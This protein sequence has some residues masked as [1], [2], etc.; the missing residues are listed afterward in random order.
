NNRGS[1]IT[2]PSTPMKPLTNADI[3]ALQNQ[4]VKSTPRLKILRLFTATTSSAGGGAGMVSASISSSTLPSPSVSTMTSTSINS[5]TVTTNQ[6]TTSAT[7][8]E[9]QPTGI[10]P[11]ITS[12]ISTVEITPA[13][14]QSPQFASTTSISPS[15]PTP[16]ASRPPSSPMMQV[17]SPSSPGSSLHAP[18][19]NHFR[20]FSITR[21][22]KNSLMMGGSTNTNSGSPTSSSSS[23]SS[24]ISSS[25][26]T[27]PG[28]KSSP[29]SKSSNNISITNTKTLISTRN[30][31]ESSSVYGSNQSG[32]DSSTSTS[33]SDDKRH[34]NVSSSSNVS[35][36]SSS[37]SNASSRSTTPTNE[38]ASKK[39]VDSEYS[40]SEMEMQELDEQDDDEQQ[41]EQPER[42]SSRVS[43]HEDDEV[44]FQTIVVPNSTI[45]TTTTKTNTNTTITKST[46]IV[47]GQLGARSSRVSIGSKRS[48]HGHHGQHGHGRVNAVS[49]RNGSGRVGGPSRM[50][51]SH[52]MMRNNSFSS[53]YSTK[54]F[55]SVVDKYMYDDQDE[56]EQQ[57]GET[58]QLGNSNDLT[59]EQ[60]DEDQ[61]DHEME[62]ED[63]T[64]TETET[65]A[66][67]I[68]TT[69]TVD[70]NTNTSKKQQKSANNGIKK[71]RFDWA[72][73]RFA[74]L[75]KNMKN[76]PG[77]PSTDTG[78]D[79][80][81]R[82]TIPLGES[83]H[84]HHHQRPFRTDSEVSTTSSNGSYIS[85]HRIIPIA[86]EPLKTEEYSGDGNRNMGRRGSD[87]HDTLLNT[88][89]DIVA[90][91][92]DLIDDSQVEM[93]VVES[94]STTS[95][96]NKV[97]RTLSLKRKVTIGNGN[98]GRKDSW[99]SNG[100]GEGIVVEED[101]GAGDCLGYYAESI[102][103]SE[104][105]GNDCDDIGE[106]EFGGE[107]DVQD[108]TLIEEYLVEH[109]VSEDGEEID[110]EEMGLDMEMEIEDVDDPS[111]FFQLA[112]ARHSQLLKTNND[113][114]DDQNED[115]ETNEIAYSRRPSH[116]VSGSDGSM[117][118]TFSSVPILMSSK[119]SI[120]S[121]EP[122][123]PI[124]SAPINDYPNTM[125]PYFSSAD[126]CSLLP[127]DGFIVVD[128][129]TV[130][131]ISSRRGSEGGLSTLTSL[132][133]QPITIIPEARSRIPSGDVD[134]VDG[135]GGIGQDKEQDGDDT[136]NTGGVVT[137]DRNQSYGNVDNNNKIYGSSGRI[138][139][140]VER[141]KRHFSDATTLPASI[142]D[143]VYLDDSSDRD[144]NDLDNEIIDGGINVNE[145]D[146]FEV[147][148]I[149]IDTEHGDTDAVSADLGTEMDIHVDSNIMFHCDAVS[150]KDL[151]SASDGTVTGATAPATNTTT[152][153][154]PT[155]STVPSLRSSVA[156]AQSI[157]SAV[158]SD[159]ITTTNTN[160][161]EITRTSTSTS[162][163]AVSASPSPTPRRVVSKV[164][165]VVTLDRKRGTSTVTVSVS[166]L[167]D[168]NSSNSGNCNASGISDKSGAAKVIES[169]NEKGAEESG[170]KEVDANAM[171]V[172]LEEG[173]GVGG[174]G[175][176]KGNDKGGKSDSG[177]GKKKV[178]FISAGKKNSRDLEGKK[179]RSSGFAKFLQLLSS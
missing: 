71:S 22:S 23:S 12:S 124:V 47:K 133:S 162:T 24:S 146:E 4:S 170:D 102:L 27:K 91:L 61:E 15:T 117:I 129:K 73:E 85:V 142:S 108:D 109:W 130:I 175:E 115:D 92:A 84:H 42:S 33:T 56:D 148:E 86:G 8:A 123:T 97:G 159:V 30:K 62:I 53:I 140:T 136:T 153:D 72:V 160:E 37:S 176:E 178:S 90:E 13:S 63:Q 18:S 93:S 116:R 144:D 150:E 77:I 89:A 55:S 165:R 155:T 2:A 17:R 34:L 106:D 98:G 67:S 152:A 168:G 174:A 79:M 1:L 104:G 107:G 16:T 120:A 58:D 128:P 20:T 149:Q 26:T 81:H 80:E 167:D 138:M 125:T 100:N 139:D 163:Q 40:E 3:E 87:G 5:A 132:S 69:S 10:I 49:R 141:R 74:D 118:L 14:P 9:K 145:P 99:N 112:N 44:A 127:D 78:V 134:E 173:N 166:I 103:G 88:Y 36:T 82:R 66:D 122:A 137:F 31:S 171:S 25:T 151:C 35:C 105:L 169:S 51:Y 179:R 45:T 6:S 172:I 111:Y 114:D 101:E 131:D 48:I 110:M 113:N 161:P 50:D 76:V 143:S 7:N 54:T 70:I 19:L 135:V 11:S 29:L 57:Q 41:R 158:E 52:L 119:A 154:T 60:E 121:T 21:V 64:E 126:P 65:D 39:P 94:T 164:R 75:K 157:P 46:S 43:F 95:G 28:K 38:D 59:S 96:K 147:S 156:S 32:D 83:N 177:E 68:V